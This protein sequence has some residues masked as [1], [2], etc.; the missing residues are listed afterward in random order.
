MM[1]IAATHRFID[2]RT[3]LKA[4]SL[5]ECKRLNGRWWKDFEVVN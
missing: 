3:T 2:V 5:E 1:S 4:E